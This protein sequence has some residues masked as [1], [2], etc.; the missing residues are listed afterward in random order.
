[1][2]S[3]LVLDEDVH[4]VIDR[5][6]QS[7]PG[8][9]VTSNR[10]P[11][12]GSVVYTFRNSITQ[13]VLGVDDGALWMPVT[14]GSLIEVGG[15]SWGSFTNSPGTITALIGSIVPGPGGVQQGLANIAP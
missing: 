7:F 8:L 15:V 12:T 14:P 4:E 13:A 3:V 10:L 2:D 9:T 5:M 11:I 6:F 1:V